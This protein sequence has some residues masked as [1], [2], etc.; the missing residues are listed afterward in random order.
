MGAAWLIIT[1][2]SAW[3]AAKVNGEC[4]P[5]N[6]YW[7]PYDSLGYSYRVICWVGYVNIE[8][9]EKQCEYEG[10]KLASVHSEYENKVVT[11]TAYGNVFDSSVLTW[12]GLRKVGGSWRW[13]DGTYFDYSN[14]APTQPDNYYGHATESPEL[15]VQVS[16]Y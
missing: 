7:E 14:W 3:F 13:T 5:G 9:A 4:A 11:E 6:Y 12:I 16:L 8:T 1:V 15:C 2:T 10:G